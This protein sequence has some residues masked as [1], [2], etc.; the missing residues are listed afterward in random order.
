VLACGE[1]AVLSHRSAAELWGLLPAGDGPVHVCVPT[2]AGRR[3]RPGLRL[4]RAPALTSDATTR[5]KSIAVTTPARTL[6][7]LPRVAPPAVVRRA[8]RQ[9]EFLGLDLG[10]IETDRTRSDLERAFLRL[11]RH[12]RLPPPEVNVR[13]GP[14][15]VDFLWRPHK[16][17]VETDGYAAHRG[18]QAFEDDRA[19]E[20]YLHA[21][22]FRVRRF[23][24]NQLL[25]HPGAVAGAV[26]AELAD[27]V[28]RL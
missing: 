17:V 22:G 19:R 12:H 4:H 3:Q 9:A 21:R 23:T 2:S 6:R 13:I 15:T 11:C 14:F 1:S 18:R 7:D 26:R 25:G 27:D 10:A 5:R 28:A 8:T 24:D 20:L 16:L